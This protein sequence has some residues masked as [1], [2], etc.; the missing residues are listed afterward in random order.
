MN[1]Y[2]QLAQACLREGGR[3][4]GE[5]K[6]KTEA[7]LRPIFQLGKLSPRGSPKEAGELGEGPSIQ[8]PRSGFSQL[9]MQTYWPQANLRSA[10]CKR[11]PL[12]ASGILISSPEESFS[13]ALMWTG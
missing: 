10:A 3:Q 7:S 1:L 4:K 6:I 13:A 8:G 11:I 9:Q 5:S 12:P 2:G